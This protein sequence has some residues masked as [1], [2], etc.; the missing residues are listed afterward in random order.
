MRFSNSLACYTHRG[1]S[2]V[3]KQ[4]LSS[5]GIVKTVITQKRKLTAIH[6]LYSY[7][8]IRILVALVT[9]KKCSKMLTLFNEVWEH[10]ES[11]KIKKS[12]H[13]NHMWGNKTRGN[14]SYINLVYEET[15]FNF[16]I[17][18]LNKFSPNLVF[19]TY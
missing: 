13:I 10:K 9:E 3:I 16:Q 8:F 7:N 2:S 15:N 12:S 18:I 1:T 11:T 17:N 6:T 4:L 19:V 14:R 5:A